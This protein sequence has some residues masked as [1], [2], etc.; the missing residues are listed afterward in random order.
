MS[1][2]VESGRTPMAG[3]VPPPDA[4]DL[5]DPT[6]D[7]AGA[8]GAAQ[9]DGQPGPAS[10]LRTSG[11]DDGHTGDAP[12]TA[13]GNADARAGVAGGGELEAELGADR[14]LGGPAPVESLPP[15]IP[16]AWARY[17]LQRL[18]L[19]LACG[20]LLYLVGLRG[21]P[22]ILA[23]FLGSGLLSFFL[24]ARTRDQA[25][26]NI[27]RKVARINRRMDERAAAEDAEQLP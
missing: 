10:T 1:S 20:A 22:L 21:V 24:L 6:R 25:A 16:H 19:L 5:V 4:A 17:S 23:A 14:D 8:S 13:D 27:E 11:T 18:L 7:A 9:I 15:E 3:Q 26:G 12:G 2:D